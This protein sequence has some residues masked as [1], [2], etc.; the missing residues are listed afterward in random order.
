MIIP[1]RSPTGL[2]DTT[3]IDEWVALCDR[4]SRAR[5]LGGCRNWILD[6]GRPDALVYC[7]DC[8]T[9]TA[10]E[11]LGRMDQRRAGRIRRAVTRF[12]DALGRGGRR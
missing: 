6:T 7:R 9:A 5:C 3:R 11:L 8:V 1:L 10:A 2:P 4:C 12:V